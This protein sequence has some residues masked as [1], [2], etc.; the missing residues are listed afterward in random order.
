[1]IGLVLPNFTLSTAEPTFSVLQ[2]IFLVITTLA[3]YGVFLAV[4]TIRHRTYFI[5]PDSGEGE[6]G[7]HAHLVQYSVT[8]H[9]I[10][11]IAYMAPVVVLAK[12]LAVPIDYAIEV[13][14]APVA[15]GGFLVAALVL[16]PEA[17]G[18]V[19]AATADQLQRSINIFLGSAAATIG[20][21]IPTVL[22]IG[23]LT[24]K[25][26]VLGLDPVGIVMLVLTL[27]VSLV[28]YASV[29]TNVLLG[30][31]HLVLFLAYILLIFD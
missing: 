18:G 17:L 6:H 16:S 22:A 20:L 7:D 5:G 29:R 10:L 30:A 25:M 15:L 12:M 9:A 4:Q 26:V 31:V 27:G 3:L 19:R 2:S 23:L 13:V 21:T 14:G 24:G 28:T 8:G 1:V 11:L